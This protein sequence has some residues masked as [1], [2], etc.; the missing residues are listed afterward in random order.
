MTATIETSSRASRRLFR[1]GIAFGVGAVF[2]LGALGVGVAYATSR[3]EAPLA[4]GTARLV[5]GDAA[6]T[7]HRG[8]PTAAADAPLRSGDELTVSRGTAIV[9]TTT[10]RLLARVGTTL[11]FG[12]TSPRVVR[13]DVLAV[14][15]HMR[16]AGQPA[17]L[18][19]NGVSRIRQGLSLEV[20]AY[21]GVTEVHTPS[22]DYEL[23]ALSRVVVAGVGGSA[24]GRTSPV[25]L[26]AADAWDRQYLGVALELDRALNERS[27]G[28]SLQAD[29][30][31]AG[32]KA[33][34]LNVLSPWSDLIP[35]GDTSV[36]EAVVAAEVATAAKLDQEHL[37]EMLLWRADGTPWG[38]IAFQL[39]LTQAPAE[40]PGVDETAVPEPVVV[41]PL[42]PATPPTTMAPPV[43]EGPRVTAPN[44]PAKPTP[45]TTTPTTSVEP[46]VVDP[47]GGLLTGVGNLLGGLLG[48]D[49]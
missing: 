35:L 27:R 26:N 49:R 20:S 29:G 30:T 11:K 1:R 37:R 21:N 8:S 13:G 6:V 10:G 14:G 43:V 47:V 23:N 15:E 5:P 25:T 24:S 3:P 16:V 34:L 40:L 28:I 44:G 22:Q 38:L 36:G 7:V 45:T 12:D 32:V 48:G 9:Q 42:A 18:V 2:C 33:R 39:G 41:T 17:Q 19:V 46:P 31:G 4:P